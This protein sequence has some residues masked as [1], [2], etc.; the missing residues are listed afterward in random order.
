MS[1]STFR[2]VGEFD[3]KFAPA[4][5]EDMDYSFRAKAKKFNLRV[6]ELAKVRHI[7]SY[8]FSKVKSKKEISKL[9]RDHRRYF[10]NK[11]FKGGDRLIRLTVSCVMDVMKESFDI[12]RKWGASENEGK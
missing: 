2:T 5:Y 1:K 9:C 11:N 10:I 3:V 4:Y 12:V 8:S 6:L 7:G